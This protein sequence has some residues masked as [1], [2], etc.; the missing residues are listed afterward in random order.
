[1]GHLVYLIVL[2]EACSCFLASSRIWTQILSIVSMAPLPHL[3]RLIMSA[4]QPTSLP[5]FSMG[6]C[7]LLLLLWGQWPNVITTRNPTHPSEVREVFLS[8]SLVKLSPFNISSALPHDTH[9]SFNFKYLCLM[10]D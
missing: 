2:L 10:F 3:S 8:L 4:S 5:S 6:S 7:F 9:L 1:M